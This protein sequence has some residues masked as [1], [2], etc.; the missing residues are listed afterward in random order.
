MFCYRNQQSHYSF[1][2]SGSLKNQLKRKKAK[3]QRRGW[4]CSLAFL[5]SAL[6]VWAGRAE[7]EANYTRNFD[8]V[9]LD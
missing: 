1:I 5:G 3:R 4:R 7:L 9:N 6:G 2:F 8:F